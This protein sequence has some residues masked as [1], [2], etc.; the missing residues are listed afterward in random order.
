MHRTPGVA[1][2]LLA[3][4]VAA[5]CSAASSGSEGDG[6]SEPN[7]SVD[8][9]FFDD[10]EG[11]SLA[12]WEDRGRPERQVIVTDPSLV[13]RG[14]GALQITYPQ[15]EDGGWLTAFF[16]P[17]Y[18]SLRVRFALR[19]EPAW[20]G[21]TKLVSFYG[22]RIDNQWSAT[23][24]ASVCPSGSDFFVATITTEPR[25][26]DPPPLRFYSYY[27]MMPREPDGRTCYG[28]YG[29]QEPEGVRADYTPAQFVLT[30]GEWHDIE[31]RVRLDFPGG[32]AAAQEIVVDG[33][34]RAAWEGIR[35]RSSTDLRLNALTI[36]ASAAFGAPR[37]QRLWI[38]DVLVTH[39]APSV[40][41][42][43]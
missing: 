13:R 14:A 8:T 19:L 38:D 35:L 27:P 43:R 40:Q 36:T 7:A 6:D 34:R 29:L 5:S 37:T 24:K 12:R 18:D 1:A 15:G 22:S 26:G 9:V 25:G 17:G 21:G 4:V 23:G 42:R 20:E 3:G 39:H 30:R 32:Q 16:L 31:Y 2:L 11:G 28:S 33:V 10:F 41:G